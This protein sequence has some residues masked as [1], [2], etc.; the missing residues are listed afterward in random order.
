M[1][2]TIPRSASSSALRWA[3]ARTACRGE[4]DLALRICLLHERGRALASCARLWSVASVRPPL[5]IEVLN[6][7]ILQRD[8]LRSTRVD[9]MWL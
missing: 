8:E 5:R 3:S 1:Q 7:S 4:P 2:V 6:Q 9:T